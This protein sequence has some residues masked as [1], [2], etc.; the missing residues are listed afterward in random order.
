LHPSH[1]PSPPNSEPGASPVAV[2]DDHSE[3]ILRQTRAA[4]GMDRAEIENL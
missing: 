1:E 3:D 2:V 4:L